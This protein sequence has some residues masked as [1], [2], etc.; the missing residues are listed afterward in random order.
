V[1]ETITA[2]QEE[3]GHCNHK[4]RPKRAIRPYQPA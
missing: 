3:P 4:K 2:E 1:R